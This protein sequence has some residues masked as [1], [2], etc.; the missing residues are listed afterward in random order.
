MPF[1]LI[2]LIKVAELLLIMQIKSLISYL[3]I[4]TCCNLSKSGILNLKTLDQDK[5][6]VGILSLSATKILPFVES[7][8][9]LK[10]LSAE[11]F[12]SISEFL[13]DAGYVADNYREW[14]AS[15]EI[16]VVPVLFFESLKEI[17]DLMEKLDGFVLTGGSESFYNYE[18]FPSLYMRTVK[19]ILQ[20]AK[21]I[22][23]SGRVFPLWGTCLGFEAIIVA[24]SGE[25]LNRKQVMNH[26]KLRETIQVT[27]NSL[28][29][30]QFF[31]E[32][33]LEDM[34]DIPLLYFNHMWGVS[35][36]DI[37]HLPEI[38]NKIKIG[39]KINTDIQ[40][41]VAVWMEFID[42][43]FFGTQ[44]HPEKEPLSGANPYDQKREEQ[45]GIEKE[46]DEDIPL[47]TQDVGVEILGDF[48]IDMEKQKNFFNVLVDSK[49]SF[50]NKSLELNEVQIRS[51]DSKSEEGSDEDSN[52]TDNESF[53]Q[54][55]TSFELKNVHVANENEELKK[56][57]QGVVGEGVDSI[58]APIVSD[59]STI[60]K[61]YLN[62]VK[63]INEKFASFFASFV[64][65]NK[66][67]ISDK[68][69]KKQMYWL[70]NIGSYYQVNVIRDNQ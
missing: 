41:N 69:L 22:N 51:K 63:R 26:V 12:T 27:D 14:L 60:S 57:N 20:K 2:C 1:N 66:I 6:K 38:E 37:Q 65:K 16:Q 35:R 36:W 56:L 31:T 18:G 52:D 58:A 29:S 61:K 45:I 68:F 54:D 21:E 33:E 13:H 67:K 44:F 40:R 5:R 25:T 9:T 55:Y 62:K 46:E 8:Y 11:D 49:N 17:S 50:N 70:E 53:A 42:Y 48:L 28:R 4:W 59:P 32:K 34:E 19:H 64:P 10:N 43:P 39:A 3:F 24:E 47:N 23:D 15:A 30:T 7:S